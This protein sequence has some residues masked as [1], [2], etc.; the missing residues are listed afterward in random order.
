V[1]IGERLLIQIVAEKYKFARLEEE[2]A[3]RHS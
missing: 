3:L 1:L 2:W